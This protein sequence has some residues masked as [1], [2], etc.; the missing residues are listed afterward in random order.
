MQGSLTKRQGKWNINE[1]SPS[2]QNSIQQFCNYTYNKPIIE[3][4]HIYKKPQMVHKFQLLRNNT[5]N[6]YSYE[7]KPQDDIQPQRHNYKQVEIYK[8]NRYIQHYKNHPKI[9]K[10]QIQNKIIFHITDCTDGVVYT[11]LNNSCMQHINNNT[12]KKHA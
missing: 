7:R 9:L 5:I 8:A 2:N 6:N 10:G 11:S 3:R 1:Q 12:L 4:T